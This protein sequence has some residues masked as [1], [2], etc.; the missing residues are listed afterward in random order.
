MPL[1]T[2]ITETGSKQVESAIVHKQ[3]LLHRA[4]HILVK[5]KGTK[6]FYIRRRPATKQ[7]Y[8]RYW[9]SSVGTHVL[10]DQ[11]VKDTA[12]ENLKK[13]L[14]LQEPLEH[15]GHQHVEDEVENEEVDF[16]LCETDAVPRLNIEQGEEARFMTLDDVVAL[17]QNET[18]TPHLAAAIEMYQRYSGLV[19]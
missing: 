3:H 14:E 5:R 8:P 16:F 19:R 18:T 9:T 1:L 15:L 4:V 17:Q 6:E 7:M 11:E 10:A 12:I 2:V 13:F